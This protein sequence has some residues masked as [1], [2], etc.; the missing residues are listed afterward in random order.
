MKC[1][2]T[3]LIPI[4]FILLA[5]VPACKKEV[6]EPALNASSLQTGRSA[7]KFTASKNINGIKSFDVNNTT[8][9]SAENRSMN[10]GDVRNIILEATELNENTITRKAY[11]SLVLR[12]NTN[13]T[14]D[15]SLASG[16]PLA[17]IHIESYGW[18]GYTR[19]S[20]SGTVNVTRF[21]GTEIEGRF[22]VTFDDGTTVS[23][24]QFA[25]KF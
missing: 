12:N 13:P 6:P 17:T 15:L 1:L 10:V 2:K 24:G 19:R 23:N 18:F 11:I 3:F 4:V 7:I 8:N 16:L 25:G 22:S 5:V 9:T 20:Q 21:T 14:I